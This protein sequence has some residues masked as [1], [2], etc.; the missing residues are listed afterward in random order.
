MPGGG[1][2]GPCLRGG[3]SGCDLFCFN[4]HQLGQAGLVLDMEMHYFGGQPIKP[5]E[6]FSPG[7]HVLTMMRLTSR[8]LAIAL[9]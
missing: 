2:G 6:G 8:S 4:M 5:K 7:Q 3:A 9:Q 1:T